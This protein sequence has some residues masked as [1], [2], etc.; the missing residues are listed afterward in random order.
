MAI[1]Y[2]RHAPVLGAKAVVAGQHKRAVQDT[3]SHDGIVRLL[4]LPTACCNCRSRNI[5]KAHVRRRVN[6]GNQ[7]T[8]DISCGQAHSTD[9]HWQLLLQVARQMH[10]L[11]NWIIDSVSSN[12]RVLKSRGATGRSRSIVSNMS[13]S[14]T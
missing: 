6:Q 8:H 13:L 9:G 10:L 14:P 11:W 1:T 5:G 2:H 3:S 7:E 12:W 4:Q